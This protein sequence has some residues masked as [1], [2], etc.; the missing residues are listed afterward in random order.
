MPFWKRWFGGT[1]RGI[2]GAGP[3]VARAKTIMH[4][5]YTIHATPYRAEG[6]FQTAGTIE[7]EVGGA[8]REHRFIRADRHPTMED[9]VEFSLHKGRQIVDQRGD[10]MFE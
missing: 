3:P 2:E 9:A 7:K 5:G 1:D 8:V 10:R 6:Q 4:A